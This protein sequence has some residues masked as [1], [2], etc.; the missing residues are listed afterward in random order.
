M[1]RSNSFDVHLSTQNT[2]AIIPRPRR[3]RHRDSVPSAPA[4]PHPARLD[5]PVPADR[6]SGAAESHRRRHSSRHLPLPHRL[7]SPSAPPTVPKARSKRLLAPAGTAFP[8][9]SYALHDAAGRCP[10][11]HAP[12]SPRRFASPC[13]DGCKGQAA[14]VRRTQM[15]RAGVGRPGEPYPETPAPGVP[16]S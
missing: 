16:P 15:A 11:G 7:V 10:A 14:A 2:L 13:A 12:E 3:R 1:V 5:V 8:L 6:E 9:R 4:V